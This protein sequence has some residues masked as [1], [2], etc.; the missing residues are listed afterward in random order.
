MAK[1]LEEE[2]AE[3]VCDL[4]KPGHEILAS[5]TPS[6][7]DLLHMAVGIS[8][9]AGE[10]LDAVKKVAIYRKPVD[11]A[12]IIEELGD[13]EFYM[14]GLRS[15][16]GIT[17]SETLEAN[18]RK[19]RVRYGKKY[20]DKS[21]QARVD[22]LAEELKVAHEKAGVTPVEIATAIA[23]ALR[24][25]PS[26]VRTLIECELSGSHLTCVDETGCCA[27]CGNK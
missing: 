10:L 9:E 2:H 13:L 11:L 26:V 1:S 8:G 6:D 16:L 22:K 21:A 18:L 25:K 20:S 14:Q 3:M 17:R 27:F 12:N 24:K 7:C 23:D 19:L 15:N 4:K 5:I